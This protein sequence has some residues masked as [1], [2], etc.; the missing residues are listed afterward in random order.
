MGYSLLAPALLVVLWAVRRAD[1][2]SRIL[3]EQRVTGDQ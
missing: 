2:R 3:A 1:K